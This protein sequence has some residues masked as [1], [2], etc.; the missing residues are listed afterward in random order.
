MFSDHPGCLRGRGATSGRGVTSWGRGNLTL[1]LETYP[2]QI[3][4]LGTLSTNVNIVD[5]AKQSDPKLAS[6][7]LDAIF[8][9]LA[10]SHAEW[11]HRNLP[12]RSESLFPSN[13]KVLWR[14]PVVSAK[15]L[16]WNNQTIKNNNFT[17]AIKTTINQLQ[18]S[19]PALHPHT[20]VIGLSYW[21]CAITAF[22]LNVF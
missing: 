19:N 2:E 11:F 18:N 6:E 15:L 5:V 14:L 22:P 3:V 1:S 7:A 21:L 10:K 13:H 4:F 9:I 16:F 12:N 17:L 20:D 8:G